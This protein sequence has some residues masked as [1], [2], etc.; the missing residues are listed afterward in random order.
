MNI[1]AESAMPG[2]LYVI[3]TPET[4]AEAL[5]IRHIRFAAEAAGVGDLKWV[6]YD[7]PRGVGV[8]FQLIPDPFKLHTENQI[9]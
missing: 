9:K 3:L 8:A 7:G 4:Q 1:T 5:Q 6:D 2:K